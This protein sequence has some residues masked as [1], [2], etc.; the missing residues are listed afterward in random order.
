MGCIV[1]KNGADTLRELVNR[2]GEAEQDFTSNQITQLLNLVA[3]QLHDGGKDVT[4]VAVGGAVNTV[5]LGSRAATGDVDFFY[6]TKQKNDDVSAVV[7]AA[8]D[9]AKARSIGQ[10]WL[11]NHT[12]VFIQEEQIAALYREA[13][14]QRA[15]VFSA[16]GLTVLAAPW[17]YALVTKLD[18][19]MK[20]G[21]KPYD[22]SD[23][24]T[25]LH[26]IVQKTQQ[27]VPRG[28]LQEWANE[29]KCTVADSSLTQSLADAY[30][31]KY[32]HAGL[33]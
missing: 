31:K 10:A 25:Y 29:F 16:P 33:S 26:E 27:P 20:P 13:Q 9:V 17:R 7:K 19:L 23:A 6:Q 8:A 5:L 1:S 24:V 2:P 30:Q 3:K 28:R 32:E 21:A 22:L 14:T 12:V 4:I 18:R 15:V 11:N